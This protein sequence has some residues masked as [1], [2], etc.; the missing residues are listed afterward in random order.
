[1]TAVDAAPV[2]GCVPAADAL[3]GR[4]ILVVGATGGFGEAAA[5]ACADAGATVVLLGRRLP[6][7]TRLYDA[8]EAS[9]APTPAIYPLDLEGAG[10][11][12]YDQLADDL[13]RQCGRLDGIVHAA[14]D[15]KGLMSLAGA[16]AE[17]LVR[18][19]H[20][21]LTAPLL[22]TRACLPL[23]SARGDAAVVFLLDDPQRIGGAH[24]GGYGL[25]KHAL[26]GAV[27]ALGD[28]LENSPVRIHG[29]QPGPMRT[30]LRARAWFG[31]DPARC[32]PAA[33]YAPAC[34][35]LLGASGRG[36]RGQVLS[37]RA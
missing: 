24:W 37:L 21:N 30:A 26:A 13:A 28:E 27:R 14:A 17:E 33:T 35:W 2:S 8:I 11:A 22:L 16:S 3:A 4:T 18:T 31:E 19:L 20:V 12:D 7:L 15:F 25:A 5:R 9:G 34:V 23:L 6:R 1:M 10:P 36:H 29:L 32:P